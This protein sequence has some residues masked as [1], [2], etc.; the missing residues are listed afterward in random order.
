MGT[1]TAGKRLLGGMLV[2]SLLLAQPSSVTTQDTTQRL[3][4]EHQGQGHRGHGG[5]A[6]VVTEMQQKHAARKH[7]HEEMTQ[8]LQQQLAALREH[9]QVLA[10]LSA[11]KPLLEEVK[12]HLHLIDALL[13]T[14]VE[15]RARLE[16]DH[17]GDHDDWGSPLGRAPAAGPPAPGRPGSPP[18][19]E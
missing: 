7:R 8:T 11:E 16:A 14:M 17:Q 6:D 5:L 4:E 3:P 9:A 12:R 15:Y 13:G 10:G 1:A 19:P 18:A 2:G